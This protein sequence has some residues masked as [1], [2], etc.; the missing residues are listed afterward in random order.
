MA[1]GPSGRAV[2]G[3]LEGTIHISDDCD[4]LLPADVARTFVTPPE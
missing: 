3:R 2:P 1:P 4:A